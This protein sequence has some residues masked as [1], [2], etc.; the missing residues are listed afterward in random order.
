VS[1][2]RKVD[3][4]I[5]DWLLEEENPSVRFWALQ[6]LRGRKRSDAEVVAAQHTVM[7]SE[8]V[9]AILKA[10]KPEG[11][12]ENRESMY[13]PKYTASTHSLLILAELGAEPTTAIRRGVE[14]MFLFQRDSGHF[15]TDIPKT[16]RGRA[17]TM[18]DACC[19]DGNILY[20]QLHFGYL[21]DAHT[22]RLIQ[23]L[24]N[25]HSKDYG[26]RCR[27]YPIDKNKVFPANCYMGA[28][29]ALKG[30]SMIPE[31]DR[32][33]DLRSVIQAEEES[34]LS[35][36]VY[37]YLRGPKGERKEKAG[38]KRFGFPLFYQ[39]DVLEVL[40]VL[41]GLGLH[42]ERMSDAIELVEKARGPDGTWALKNTFNGKML[43]NIDTKNRP[44]KWVTLRAMRV[45]KRWYRAHG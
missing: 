45:L 31:K 16:E 42:D 33:A 32:S 25:D 17:T 15:L 44:S 6:Q 18:T 21:E 39:S 41:T 9:K 28:V 23:F 10:Q 29:K 5:V 12:W 14:Y 26:W 20:Y 27:S 4:Q 30:L 8:C 22:K 2:A 3:D 19:L 7:Q 11:H 40:D 37:R 38:W 1:A 36:Q 24:L 35:N 13:L 34:I 43:C